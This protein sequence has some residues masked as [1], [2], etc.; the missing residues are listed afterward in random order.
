[1]KAILGIMLATCILISSNG[2]AF[3]VKD[4]TSDTAQPKAT[5]AKTNAWTRPPCV[6]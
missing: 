3:S 4:K 2:Y 6:L 5:V 1:M